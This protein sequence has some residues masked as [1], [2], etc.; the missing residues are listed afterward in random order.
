MKHPETYIL[1]REE[2]LDINRA[3]AGAALQLNFVVAKGEEKIDRLERVRN[4][5]DILSASYKAAKFSESDI[6]EKA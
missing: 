3:L 6:G 2:W 4:A 5:Q 1:S